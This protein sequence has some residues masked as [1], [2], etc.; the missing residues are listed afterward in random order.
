MNKY[1]ESVIE[2][3]RTKH[4]NEPE[5]VQT[6]EEVLS[7]LDPVVERHPEYENSTSSTVLSNRNGNSHSAS[8]GRTIK[9]NTIPIRA[10]ASSST[11]L[12][13]PTKAASVSRKTYTQASSNSWALNRS[14]RT[15]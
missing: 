4:A 6:V 7:S 1:L 13:G 9:A 2:N 8:S 15:P 5:F 12:S 10:T 3:V 11:A 14:S